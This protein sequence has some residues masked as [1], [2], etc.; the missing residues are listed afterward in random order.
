MKALI[1]GADVG[2]STAAFFLHKVGI[3]V[4]IFDRADAARKSGVA[5]NRRSIAMQRYGVLL[6]LLLPGM[7]AANRSWR[8]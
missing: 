5:S 4:E 6:L 7:L 2:G 8:H 3:E 1:V